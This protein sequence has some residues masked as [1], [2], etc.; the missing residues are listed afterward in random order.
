[1]KSIKAKILGPVVVLAVLVLVTSVFSILGAGNIEKKGRVISDQYLATIQDVSAMSKNTQTLMR[2]S[3]NY[4]LA[5]SDSAEKKVETSISQTKQTLENQMADFSNNL[6][7]EE[8]EAF[9]KFQSD[10]QAYLSK[11]NAMVKYVQTDQNENASIVANN[12]LV[13]MSSQI[14][15]DLENMIELESSLADQAVA[16]MESAYASSMG[17]GIVCLLLGIVALVAA[18]IISN[19]RVGKLPLIGTIRPSC[20]KVSSAVPI[21]PATPSSAPRTIP[22]WITVLTCADAGK[23]FCACAASAAVS[24]KRRYC[25]APYNSQRVS[26]NTCAELTE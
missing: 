24:D 13:E 15:T 8:T 10:Y 21:P 17:V 11:Y 1:M 26:C 9:Q 22:F 19:R 4:I 2:L 12:D 3:Y 18:I 7:P 23:V 25:H 5:Q 6:T 20:A 14:E 16:N